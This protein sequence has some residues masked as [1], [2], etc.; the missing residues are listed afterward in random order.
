[1]MMHPS[2]RKALLFLP[3]VAVAASFPAEAKVKKGD[4]APLFKSI[5]EDHQPVDMKDLIAGKPLVMAVGS[6]S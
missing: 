6:A 1:M 3:A 5:N 2:M 4:K